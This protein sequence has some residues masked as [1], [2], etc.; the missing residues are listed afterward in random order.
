MPI[1]LKIQMTKT[2]VMLLAYKGHYAIV[3]V[4]EK[5]GMLHQNYYRSCQ[6]VK[7]T[8]MVQRFYARFL[9]AKTLKDLGM[10][11]KSA[12]FKPSTNGS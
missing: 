5:L 8:E 3:R 7:K 6:D 1:H 12:S 2:E 9:V 4:A 11:A 10:V